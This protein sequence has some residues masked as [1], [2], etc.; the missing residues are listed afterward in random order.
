MALLKYHVN[1]VA[2]LCSKYAHLE[3]LRPIRRETELAFGSRPHTPPGAARPSAALEALPDRPRPSVGTAPGPLRG[4]RPLGGCGACCGLRIGGVPLRQPSASAAGCRWSGCASPSGHTCLS[5]GP[6]SLP[7]VT[8]AIR[9]HPALRAVRRPPQ[10]R[11]L[12]EG[13]PPSGPSPT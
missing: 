8:Q 12:G 10:A 4:G 3:T 9:A 7:M 11:P 1:L 5:E 2:S 6:P 13:K